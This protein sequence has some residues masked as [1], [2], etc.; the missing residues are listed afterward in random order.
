MHTEEAIEF[1]IQHLAAGRDRRRSGPDVYVADIT[2]GYW[3]TRRENYRYDELEEQ[4]FQPFYDAAW[5][6]CRIGV[7]R[8]GIAHKSIGAYFTGAEF[9]LTA[10][11]KAWLKD[12]SQRPILDPSRLAGLLQNFAARFGGGYAQRAT[13]AVRTCRTYNYLAA[14]VMAGAAAESILLALAIAKAKDEGK[15][16]SEYKSS[17]GRRN[18]TSRLLTGVTQGIA[19]QFRLLLQVLHYWRDD[20][21]HGTTTTISEIEAHASLTQLLRLGQ[22]A[23]DHWDKLTASAH[24]G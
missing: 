4:D 18:V 16:L 21:A 20:A 11:G 12:A 23:S 19:D 1:L 14:C 2:G 24:A 8:P 15:V 13:E 6:L 3:S 17:N 10:F 5:D 9:M 7:L 22:L